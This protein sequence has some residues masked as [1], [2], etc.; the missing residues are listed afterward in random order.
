M[1]LLLLFCFFILSIHVFAQKSIDVLLSHY[2][3][4][5]VPYISVQ[6]LRMEPDKYLI[7]DTRKREEYDVSHIPGAIWVGE[8]THENQLKSLISNKNQPIMVYC[9]VGIRS[10]DFGEKMEKLGY[11]NVNNLYGSIFAWK[12]AGFPVIDS[13][14]QETERVHVYGPHWGKYLE[15]GT[16]VY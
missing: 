16:K 12:D 10:E 3:T 2:N 13:S 9:S 14:G 5:S 4:R 15:T 1:R 6:E 7:L 11:S 8:K